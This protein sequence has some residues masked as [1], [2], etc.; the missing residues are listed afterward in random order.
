MYVAESKILHIWAVCAETDDP[1]DIEMVNIGTVYIYC[2]G[3]ALFQ[4]SISRTMCTF[5]CIYVNNYRFA[6]I[7]T[8][9]TGAKI[10]KK[11]VF[12]SNFQNKNCR[13]KPN[14]INVWWL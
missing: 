14:R 9:E 5:T 3:L 6:W 10:C 4:N 12:L 2:L 8:I 11:N 7:Y 13:F 1:L